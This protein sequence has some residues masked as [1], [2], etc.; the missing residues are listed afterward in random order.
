MNLHVEF[1]LK[2]TLTQ[3]EVAKFEEFISGH[4]YCNG[5]HMH[6]SF[7]V[8]VPEDPTT[9]NAGSVLHAHSGVASFAV[10]P[11]DGDTLEA[12]V[13]E[14]FSRLQDVKHF[15]LQWVVTAVMA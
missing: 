3:E 7:D 9:S 1:D 4:P 10:Y 11:V 6:G 15:E 14:L 5:F 8:P 2:D 12:H 13:E